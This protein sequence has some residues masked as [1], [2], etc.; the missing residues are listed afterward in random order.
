M[1]A[2]N[3][4]LD[5]VSFVEVIYSMYA[6]CR[7]TLWRINLILEICGSMATTT[8]ADSYVPRCISIYVYLSMESKTQRKGNLITRYSLVTTWKHEKLR[9][10]EL[11]EAKYVDGTYCEG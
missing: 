5:P 4:I 3:L 8:R 9:V 1:H 2:C 10:W 11:G 6:S 7:M